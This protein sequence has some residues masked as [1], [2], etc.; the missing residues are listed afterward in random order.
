MKTLNRHI[1]RWKIAIQEYR[2]NMTMVHK[3]GNIHNNSDGLGICALANTPDNPT[4]VPLEAEPKIAIEEINI[5]DIG[6]E[7]FE[8][9]SGHCSTNSCYVKKG[10]NPRLPA[11]ILRKDLIYIHPTAFSFKIILD[12]VKHHAKQS[13]NDAFD[14]EKQKWDKSH[15]LPDFK[16]VD[17]VLVSTWSLNNIKGPKKHKDSYVEPFVIV[18]LHGTNAVQV[19]VSGE[20]ENKHPTF[21]VR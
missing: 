14:Y 21:P 17:F 18:A 13:M 16:L 4:Y 1:L 6:T 8:E 11:D 9:T 7:F 3:S 12:K 10:W 20:L 5:T 19:K 2:G 15:K